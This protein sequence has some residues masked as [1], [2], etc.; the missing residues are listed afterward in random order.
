[1]KVRDHTW[2]GV[3]SVISLGALVVGSVI[4]LYIQNWTAMLIVAGVIGSA[5]AVS[6]VTLVLID[7]IWWTPKPW[8]CPFCGYDRRGLAAAEVCP[9]CGRAPGA[10]RP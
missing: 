6:A 5:L 10:T 9:E 1:M 7:R 2:L 8:E 4:S 3:A